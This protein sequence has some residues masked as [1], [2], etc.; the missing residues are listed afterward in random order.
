M[1]PDHYLLIRKDKK[2]Q[3]KQVDPKAYLQEQQL[4][5]QFLQ[6]VPGQLKQQGR[7]HRKLQGQ[8]I[9]GSK[10]LRGINQQESLKITLL[11]AENSMTGTQGHKLLRQE[12]EIAEKV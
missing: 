7:Q 3:I 4:T 12:A 8:Q 5:P 6:Q 2:D 1:T 11:Q 10:L 9:H